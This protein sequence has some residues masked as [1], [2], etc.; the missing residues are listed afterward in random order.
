MVLIKHDYII[1]H[2]YF[3]N[4]LIDELFKLHL[5]LLTKIYE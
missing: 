2:Y 4:V 5:N 1:N 3:V